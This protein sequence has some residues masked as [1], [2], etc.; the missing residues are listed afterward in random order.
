MIK[1]CKVEDK[2]Y[3]PGAMA[4]RSTIGVAYTYD[5]KHSIN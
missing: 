4:V 2:Y 5:F 3:V 1:V